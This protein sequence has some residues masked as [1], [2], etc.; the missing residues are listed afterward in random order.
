[1]SWTP[2]TAPSDSKY[3][4]G[5]IL[6]FPV[7]DN[8]VV[9]KGDI[10]RINADG[11]ATG[12]T[13]APATGDICAGVALET[14]DNTGIGHVSGAKSVSVATEGVIDVY[15]SGGSADISSVGN[16]AYNSASSSDDP[17]TIQLGVTNPNS[18]SVCLVGAIVGRVFSADK[19]PDT[20]RLR[21]KLLTFREI[22][23]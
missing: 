18:G 21:M 4:D 23:P 1:M 9:K 13:T 10:V 22:A 15:L 12:H 20:N 17:H 5:K 7:V 11:Y 14:V 6:T 2:L 8:V 16:L 3:K 19:V